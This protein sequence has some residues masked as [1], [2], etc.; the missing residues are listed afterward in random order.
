MSLTNR[1]EVAGVA[2]GKRDRI[3]D[4]KLINH[5]SSTRAPGT[6]NP[7]SQKRIQLLLDNRWQLP[8]QLEFCCFGSR[9]RVRSSFYAIFGGFAKHR[10]DRSRTESSLINTKAVFTVIAQ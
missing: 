1:R 4:N 5:Q 7:A 8:Q 3:W 6:R 2:A 9:S 10:S